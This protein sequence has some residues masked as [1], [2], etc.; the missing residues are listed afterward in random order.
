MGSFF[1]QIWALVRKTLIT[2]VIRHPLGTLLRALVIPIA[3]LV[4]ILELKSL[5][6][7]SHSYGVA[8]PTPIRKFDNTLVG[9]K[10]FALVASPGLGDD[11]KS[12]VQ[13]LSSPLKE[14]QV[15]HLSDQA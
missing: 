13:K 3:L 9:D 7:D 2:A 8:K 15:M 14:E 10:T 5:Q 6:A 1:A 4:V 12:I 11:V